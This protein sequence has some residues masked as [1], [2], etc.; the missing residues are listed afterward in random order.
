MKYNKEKIV[1]LLVNNGGR[2]PE[3]KA[4]NN[5]EKN[6]KARKK[7]ND[8]ENNNQ[9][10]SEIISNIQTPRK[11]ILVKIGKNGEKTLKRQKKEDKK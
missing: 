3:P 6:K 8:T 1:E 10:K 9:S 2:K 11:Y 7:S 5:K 4:K